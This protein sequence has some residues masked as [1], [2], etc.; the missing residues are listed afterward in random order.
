MKMNSFLLFG[1]LI[2]TKAE[3][4]SDQ[5]SGPPSGSEAGITVPPLGGEPALHRRQVTDWT[6]CVCLMVQNQRR[7]ALVSINVIGCR[8]LRREK[9]E[10]LHHQP[11][12]F[13]LGVD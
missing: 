1:L 7:G 5:V 11:A 4:F 13:V 3:S 12:A 2:Q 9:M 10:L 8:P 6:L